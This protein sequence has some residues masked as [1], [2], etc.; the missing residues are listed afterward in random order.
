MNKVARFEIR[1]LEREKSGDVQGPITSS[2][3]FIS[4]SFCFSGEK[5]AERRV[6]GRAA[7]RNNG[8]RQ[9]GERKKGGGKKKAC[10]KADTKQKRK[11][12]KE[13]LV[14]K[15]LAHEKAECA[16]V[17]GQHLAKNTWSGLW[18]LDDQKVDKEACDDDA[19]AKALTR[20]CY[21]MTHGVQKLSLQSAFPTKRKKRETTNEP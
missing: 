16:P 15:N 14:E 2:Q 9:G 20:A 1:Y 19:A 21:E 11:H 6:Q 7:R 17:F 8:D 18:F 12:R 3:S 13:R 4:P 5:S 10:T